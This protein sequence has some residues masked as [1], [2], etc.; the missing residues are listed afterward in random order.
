MGELIYTIIAP[1]VYICLAIIEA[2]GKGLDHYILAEGVCFG[3][4]GTDTSF[5]FT[6]LI[7]K[8]KD[9]LIGDRPRS[10]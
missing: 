8:R 2:A 7:F 6:E 4:E 1:K 5:D 9:R 3:I 10:V